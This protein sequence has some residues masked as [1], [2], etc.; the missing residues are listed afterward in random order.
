MRSSNNH[1]PLSNFLWSIVLSGG[2]GQRMRSH[3]E[4]WKGQHIPKQYCTFV[5]TRSMLQHTWDRADRL[6]AANHKVTVLARTH[7]HIVCPHLQPKTAGRFVL[8]PKNRNT[9]AGIF[10]PLTYVR[11][12][13]PDATVILYPSDHFIYPEGL[14]INH[15]RAAVRAT[16]HWT[17]RIILLGAIPTGPE[18]DYGWVEKQLRLGWANAVPLWSVGSF[19]EK[20]SV[21]PIGTPAESRWLWNTMVMVTKVQTLW[22]V[23]WQCFPLLMERFTALAEV[24]GTQ[25]ESPILEAI[26]E[27]MPN[28][29]FSTELLEGAE[30]YLAVMEMHNVL[31][32]DWGRPERV[33]NTLKDIGKVPHFPITPFAS[34]HSTDHFKM[35][36]IQIEQEV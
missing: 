26:Y 25:R 28:Q 18:L 29:N 14:F 24:L 31:W 10:L 1:S 7:E 6:T 2:E 15:V 23:G 4:Q 33:V 32:S 13:N 20:P 17:D 8:Q 27:D 35:N 19:R 36:T 30:E 11:W 9:A 5:G 12:W 22:D 16:E 34:T 3:I 21:L